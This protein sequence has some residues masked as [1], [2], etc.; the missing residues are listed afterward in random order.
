MLSDS[1]IAINSHFVSSLYK[2]LEIQP[3]SVRKIFIT[4]QNTFTILVFMI[5]FINTLLIRMCYFYDRRLL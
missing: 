1:I 4:R 3:P 2:K 5:Y